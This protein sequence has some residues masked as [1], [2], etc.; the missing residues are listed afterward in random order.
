MTLC[1]DS[2]RGPF[3]MVNKP[4]P[5]QLYEREFQ[6]SNYPTGGGLPLVLY[7][8]PRLVSTGTGSRQL[9]WCLT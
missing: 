2:H 1:Y 9:D 4:V 3:T 6:N 5:R 7:N 8:R